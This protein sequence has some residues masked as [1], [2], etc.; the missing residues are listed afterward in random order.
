LNVL[1]DN[2]PA[3]HTYEQ[4]GFERIGVYGEYELEL[5]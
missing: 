4:L 1:C 3:I 5:K 2:A